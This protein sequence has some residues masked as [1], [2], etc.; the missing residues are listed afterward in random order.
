MSVFEA[1]E[2]ATINPE[3]AGEAHQ[4]FEHYYDATLSDLPG[5]GLRWRI[6][7]ETREPGQSP[8]QQHQVVIWD[9]RFRHTYGVRFWLRED[10]TLPGYGEEPL[11]PSA[12][13]GRLWDY[14]RKEEAAQ[15]AELRDLTRQTVRAGK[16]RQALY[17]LT[18]VAFVLTGGVGA[19]V[20]PSNWTAAGWAVCCLLLGTSLV[21]GVWTHWHLNRKARKL[22]RA[23]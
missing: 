15:Q 5:L 3:A 21:A 8:E 22:G 4:L 7:V 12:L 17:L 23:Y 13:W 10:G 16:I 2:V 6:D 11:T 18:A 14:Q 9:P 1:G 20:G 19:L